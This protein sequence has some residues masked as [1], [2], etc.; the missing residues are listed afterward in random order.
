MATVDMTVFDPAIDHTALDAEWLRQA[1]MYYA[2][3]GRVAQAR[4]AAEEAKQELDVARAET[5][6]AIRKDPA[7]YG[8]DKVTEATVE[9]LVLTSPA[10]KKAQAAHN[11]ARYDQDMLAAAVAAL[12]HKKKALEYLTDLQGRN[13]HSEP[14][15][16]T[17][18]AREAVAENGKRAARA[19][20]VRQPVKEPAPAPVAADEEDWS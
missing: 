20:G 9:A 6:L 4:R 11:A 8:C 16:R 14:Q 10:Y 13:Y 17:P 19:K 2:A 5:A 15:A 1:T 18:A 3:A 12:D 7:A